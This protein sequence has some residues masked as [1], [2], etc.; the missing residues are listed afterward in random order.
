M[1]DRKYFIYGVILGVILLLA[2]VY[3]RPSSNLEI[4]FCDVGQGDGALIKAKGNKDV[5]IDG[6]PN[7]K[8]LTCLGENMPFYDKTIDVVILTHPQKDH[9]Y[10][11]IEVVKR[12]H[13][14]QVILPAIVSQDDE[15]LQLI[16]S[17]AKKRVPVKN[18]YE[19]DRFWIGEIQFDVLWPENKFVNTSSQELTLKIGE[20]NV[21]GVKTTDVD[22]NF[23]SYVMN[24]SY[25]GLN[26]LFTGDGDINIQN[27]ILKNRKVVD[28]DILKVPHHGSKNA[29]STSYLAVTKPELAIISVGK[30]SYGHPSVEMLQLLQKSNAMTLRT[31]KN[32]NIRI[33]SDGKKWWV[34]K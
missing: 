20:G 15:Y 16:N 10:G 23:F 13:L 4:V 32:G 14:K 22:P 24:L 7:N 21:L 6:G 27:D 8:I 29:L 3:F 33:I 11:L 28:V 31:D 1:L 25:N 34:S 2:F 19:G 18:L 26:V 17:L 12:F 30:N 5:L 9:Y